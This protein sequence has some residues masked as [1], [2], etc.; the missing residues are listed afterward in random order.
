[1]HPILLLGP[2]RLHPTLAPLL[3]EAGLLDG[4]LAVVTAGWEDRE[5]ETTELE[6]HLG[7]PVVNLGLYRRGEQAFA[8]DPELF[9]AYRRRRVRIR[10]QS[11]LYRLRLAHQKQALR[12]LM[13]RPGPS[14]LLDD[15]IEHALELLRRLDADELGRIQA[16]YDEFEARWRPTEREIV[17]GHR[18]QIDRLLGSCSALLVAG[19]NVAVLYNRLRLFGLASALG[20]RPLVAW[21]AGAMVLTERIVLFHDDPPQGFG[22]P[23]IYGPGFGLCPGLVVLPHAHDRL[24]LESEARVARLARRLAPAACVALDPRT[25]LRY[26]GGAYTPL[27]EG[28]PRLTAEGGVVPWG[29][30]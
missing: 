28:A 26:E 3:S 29:R 24:R 9:A 8:A 23:E 15:A 21:S 13:R 4:R 17:A 14:D 20:G 12:D 27:L 7:H 19:G 11:E 6:A 16:L 30:P 10:E 18:H 5:A 2:Q 1:V 25:G 22:D